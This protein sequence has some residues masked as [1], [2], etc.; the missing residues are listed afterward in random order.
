MHSLIAKIKKS[1]YV[2]FFLFLT[3][4][5]LFHS[6]NSVYYASNGLNLWFHKMIPSLFPFMVISGIMVRLRLTEAV[7]SLF[8]PVIARVW[9]V[10]KN[11]TYAMFMGFLCGFPMGARVTCDLLKE[12]L[13][14]TKE[15]KF[16]LA[17]CNNIGPVY[18]TGYMLPLLGRKLVI[19]YM[20]GMYGVPLIYSLILRATVYRDLPNKVAY[21]Q[22]QTNNINHLS[23]KIDDAIITSIKS[24]LMLGGYM[25][26]FNLFNLVP[27]YTISKE[28]SVF[29]APILEITGGLAILGTRMPLYSLLILPFGGLCCIA[30]TYSIIKESKLSI[31]TYIYHKLILVIITAIYYLG[32]KYLFP[33]TFLL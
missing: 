27:T 3:A 28:F 18:V 5:M 7:V 32:W 22:E 14:T 8:H 17:F 15:A 19:P 12:N 10:Q 25:I 30:Q 4:L 33:E 1:I 31:Y 21:K 26:L 13:I 11:V 2:I 29:V 24:M 6:E 23:E 16:L 9:K 20:L